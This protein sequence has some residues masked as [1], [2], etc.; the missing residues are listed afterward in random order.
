MADAVMEHNSGAIGKPVATPR[1]L[2]PYAVFAGVIML[3]LIYFVG[4]EQG[5]TSMFSGQYVH[6]FMHD[7]RHLLAFP[8]H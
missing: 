4:G 5:A 2:L 3:L 8:C 1:E 7:G 6:E